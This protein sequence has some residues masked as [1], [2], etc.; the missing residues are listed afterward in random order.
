MNSN[1]GGHA[2]RLPAETLLET[3]RPLGRPVV[4]AGGVGD[5]REFVRLL[6][7][8][9]DGVQLGTRFIATRECSAHQSYKDALVRA[10]GNDI[11]L[12]ERV[13]AFPSP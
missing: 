7:L 5:E 10:T 2:G 3:L 4:A 9:Y 11:V 8:G 6:A 12:T 1:A 13:T